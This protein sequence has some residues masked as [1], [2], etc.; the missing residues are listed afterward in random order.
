[1][2]AVEF[3]SCQEKNFKDDQAQMFKSLML[4]KFIFDL[5]NE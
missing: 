3:W 4:N 5:K 1:M 2:G